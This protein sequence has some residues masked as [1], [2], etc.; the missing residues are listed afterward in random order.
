MTAGRGGLGTSAG[1]LPYRLWIGVTGHRTLGDVERLSQA[2]EH[3]LARIREQAPFSPATPTRFGIVSPLAEGADRLVAHAV[4]RDQEATLEAALPLTPEDYA[5]DFETDASREEFFSLL[6]RA[7]MVSV[8]PPAGSRE[9]AYA[10]VGDYVVDRCDVLVA[11]WDGLPPRGVGGTADIVAHA[12][13]RGVP[14]FLIDT[15]NGPPTTLHEETGTGL[16]E[17]DFREVDAFNRAE[18]PAEGFATQV[19]RHT[20]QL[21]E[22]SSD[23]GLD[24]AAVRPYLDWSVPHLVRADL[25]AQRNQRQY[26]RLGNLLFGTAFLAVASAAVQ[27]LFP[28]AR[29]AVLVEVLLMVVLLLTVLYGRRRRLHARWI[30][31]RKLAERFRIALFQGVSALGQSRLVSWD[32]IDIDPSRDWVRRLFEEAWMT[33]PLD[34]TGRFSFPALRQFLIRAWLEDQL[35]YHWRTMR[36]NERRERRL[37]RTIVLLFG[38]TLALAL[39]RALMLT[40]EGPQGA[41]LLLLATTVPALGTALSGIRAQREYLQNAEKSRQMAN[42]LKVL[43]RRMEVAPDLASLQT[44]VTTMGLLMVDENQDWYATMQPHDF[45]VPL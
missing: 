1:G 17:R 16:S 13:D 28:T 11:L 34:A 42:H 33:R 3:V 32:R 29:S 21:L 38:L 23:V 15:N 19:A 45:E 41:L 30:S 7:R 20:E 10:Q 2:I 25:L 27:S 14:L 5:K 22:S 31:Y 4:L 36:R 44:T 39:G 43:R 6:E 40:D 8:M 12:R 26:L 35:A 9:E 18:L 24:E 37:S